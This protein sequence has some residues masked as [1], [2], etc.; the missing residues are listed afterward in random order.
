MIVEKD[1]EKMKFAA[2]VADKCGNAEGERCEQAL[3]FT[4]C[5]HAEVTLTHIDMDI[6]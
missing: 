4:K 3:T 1:P 5:V 6:I 2:E